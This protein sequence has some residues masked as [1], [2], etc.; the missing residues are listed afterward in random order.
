MKFPDGYGV[1]ITEPVED[2]PGHY[3]MLKVSEL[4]FMV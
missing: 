4:I 3:F 1:I 2:Y